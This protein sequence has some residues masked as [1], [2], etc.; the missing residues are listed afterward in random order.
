MAI[1]KTKIDRKKVAKKVK[2]KRVSKTKSSF[3]KAWDFWKTVQVD[4]SN[5]K[6]DREEAN[7]I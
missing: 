4:L 3:D 1:T 6:F 5:F 7:A 2:S